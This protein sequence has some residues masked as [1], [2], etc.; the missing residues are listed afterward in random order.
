MTPRKKQTK[1]KRLEDRR[2][3]LHPSN[4]TE[5]RNLNLRIETIKNTSR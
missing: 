3:K 1:I 4:E 5:I 2:N